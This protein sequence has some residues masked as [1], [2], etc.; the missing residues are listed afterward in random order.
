[1][2]RQGK[3]RK[4][5]QETIKTFPFEIRD[6]FKRLVNEEGFNNANVKNNNDTIDKTFIDE[7]DLNEELHQ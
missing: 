2:R 5:K 1:M 3:A 7:D 4:H 6:R